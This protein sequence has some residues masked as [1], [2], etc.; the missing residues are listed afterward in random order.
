M[1]E[2]IPTAWL[3][4]CLEIM[5]ADP[6]TARSSVGLPAGIYRPELGPAIRDLECNV[7]GAG[8]AGIIGEPCWWCQRG[9]EIQLEHQADLLLKRPDVH[10]DDVTY[11]ARMDAWAERLVRG[12]E[13]GIITERQALHAGR[14][15]DRTVA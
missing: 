7:C 9:R 10:P 6:E 11:G 1:I 8:W 12:V 2:L 15:A 14:S 5:D 4:R 3:E 13:A